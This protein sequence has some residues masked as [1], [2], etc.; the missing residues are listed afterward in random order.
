MRECFTL[1]LMRFQICQLTGAGM[2]CLAHQ[3]HAGLTMRQTSRIAHG[4]F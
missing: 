2:E 3:V 1:G 4:V